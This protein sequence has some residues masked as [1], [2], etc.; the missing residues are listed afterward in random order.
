MSSK[1]AASNVLML[2][3]A[4]DKRQEQAL[5]VAF[6][7]ADSDGDGKLTV[8]EY[9]RILQDHSINTTKEEI[10]NL[11][12]IADKTKDGYI[13]RAEF[14]GEASAQTKTQEMVEKAERAFNI[15]D[16]NHDGYITKSEMLQTTKKLTEKQIEAVFERNDRDGDGKLSKEEFTE[17]MCREKR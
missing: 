3:K 14:M 6:K 10:S 7:K 17:M 9:F 5:L 4:G 13:T 15:I 2:K 12:E 11:M 8:D 1:M 16:R